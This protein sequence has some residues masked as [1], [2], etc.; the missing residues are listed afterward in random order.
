M[1]LLGTWSSFIMSPVAIYFSETSNIFSVWVSNREI[2]H[3]HR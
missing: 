2:R 1:Q 3:R